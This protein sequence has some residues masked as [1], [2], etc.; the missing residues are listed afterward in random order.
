MRVAT[1]NVN[2]LRSRLD[3]VK[4]WLR[5]R[6]P[7][8]VA[9]QE[10][11]LED[12][13]FP[14]DALESEGYFAAVHGQKAWNG[15][16][17]LARTKPELVQKGLSGQEEF[18]S[19][20]LTAKVGSLSFTSLYCP[21][22]KSVDHE[23]FRRKL[24]WLESLADHLEVSSITALP[25]IVCGDFNICPQ[26]IDSYNEAGKAGKIF[27]TRE[28]RRSFQALLDLGFVDLYRREHPERQAFSW[29]DYRAGSFHKNQ[30]LRI[31]FLLASPGA[32]EVREVEIDR[33][34]RKKQEGL[35]PSDHAPVWADL[36][37]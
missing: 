14:H 24:A 6:Q 26:G 13:K 34:F 23:D 25:A 21:N 12:D 29:W 5:E 4:L 9:L 18:G 7:D 28:E 11:K 16:A 33:E 19:R 35:T 2:G 22:G 3:F 10:L 15:V 37:I 20:L 8:A 27:H 17:V 36:D 30:G 1:W 31:D 32:S